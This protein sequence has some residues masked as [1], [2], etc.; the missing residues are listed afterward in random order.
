MPPSK[1][2]LSGDIKY[3]R[4]PEILQL[5]AMDRLTGRLTLKITRQTV[6]IY[7]RT[8]QVVFAEGEKRGV[9]EQIGSILVRMGALTEDALQSALALS[10]ARGERLGQVLI[11][12]SIVTPE[13][14]KKALLVQTERSVYRAM[15]WGQ[16]RFSFELSDMPEYIHE[17]VSGIRVEDLIL[18]GIRRVNEGRMIAEK[19]PSLDIIFARSSYSKDEL[20]GLPIK[21]DERLVLALVDGLRDIKALAFASGISEFRLMKALFA[22]FSAGIIRRQS[23]T[24]VSR[25]NYL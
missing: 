11:D 24:S 5:I 4:L 21:E 9:R 12:E 22:L 8:G 2:L 25:T 13:D 14:I 16:G 10:A 18:E 15:A 1:S 23:A 20:A 3:F 17:A 19:I 6:I 7:I